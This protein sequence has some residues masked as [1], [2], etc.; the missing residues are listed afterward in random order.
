[1]G[2]AAGS[3]LGTLGLGR[4]E[5]T[6]DTGPEEGRDRSATIRSLGLASA[7][8]AQTDTYLVGIYLREIVIGCAGSVGLVKG[9]NVA[10]CL[11]VFRREYMGVGLHHLRSCSGSVGALGEHCNLGSCLLKWYF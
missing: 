1:V 3:D 8:Q 4:W 11:K 5:G 10:C 6:A 9:S 7:S 2:L